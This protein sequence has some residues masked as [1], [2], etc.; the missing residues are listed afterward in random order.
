[1][2]S[3]AKNPSKDQ[4]NK[5]ALGAIG[6]VFGDI[7]TTPSGKKYHIFNT[8]LKISLQILGSFGRFDTPLQPKIFNYF[9]PN[10]KKASI[11]IGRF[12]PFLQPPLRKNLYFKLAVSGKIALRGLNAPY[13][14]AEFQPFLYPPPKK[15]FQ[16]TVGSVL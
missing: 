4:L 2:S 10:A 16:F 15:Q 7:G 13:H 11:D 14:I 12:E 5:L 3:N 9:I 6:V 8:A 1:M